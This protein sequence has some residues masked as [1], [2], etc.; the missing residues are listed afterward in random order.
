MG[1]T[2]LGSGTRE[3]SEVALIVRM[4]VILAQSLSQYLRATPA[5]GLLS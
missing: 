1:R 3:R 5:S 4:L 2:Q